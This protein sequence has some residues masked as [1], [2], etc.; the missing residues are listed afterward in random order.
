MLRRFAVMVLVVAGPFAG[1]GIAFAQAPASQEPTLNGLYLCTGTSPGGQEYK[2]LVEIAQ[3]G[4][5]FHVLWTFS[6]ENIALG[7]GI[8]RD[9]VLAVSYY[10]KAAGGV[11]LYKVQDD[12]S[13]VGDWTVMGG[14]GRVFIETLSRV[15]AGAEQPSAPRRGKPRRPTARTVPSEV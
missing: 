6:P 11:V 8:L 14:D 12:G 10:G 2:G 15:P 3:Q 9:R 7:I 13:L 5:T 4:D 1:A